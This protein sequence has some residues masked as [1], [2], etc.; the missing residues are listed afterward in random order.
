MNKQ[1][2]KQFCELTANELTYCRCNEN[3]EIENANN[4]DGISSNS[5]LARD[6]RVKTM[7]SAINGRKFNS[8]L[9]RSTAR[10]RFMMAT[11]S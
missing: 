2:N 10:Y 11:S 9:G 4:N 8:I 7:F 1:A 3:D 5:Q 6:K